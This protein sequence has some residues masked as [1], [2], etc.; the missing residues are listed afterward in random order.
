MITGDHQLIAA[1]TCRALGM[2]TLVHT[3]EVLPSYEVGQKVPSTL[4]EQY[5]TLVL[6]ADGFA[7]V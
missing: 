3:A 6:Q 4:H 7:Q 5:G 1:E 2:G